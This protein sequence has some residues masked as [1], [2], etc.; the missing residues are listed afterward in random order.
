MQQ[1]VIVVKQRGGDAAFAGRILLLSEHG[2][3]PA[4]GIRFQPAHGAAFVQYEDQF[5]QFLF[6]D[7]ILLVFV[8]QG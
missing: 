6:H 5:R 2:V 7:A 4:D 1:A 8:K 3:E